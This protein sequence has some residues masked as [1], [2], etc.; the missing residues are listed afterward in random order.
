[1]AELPSGTITF[2]FTDIEGSTRLIQEL[3]E[4]YEALFAAHD[5]LVRR[6]IEQAGGTE[7]RTEGDS[8]FVVFTSASDAVHAAVDV[9]RSLSAHPWPD[10]H[11][12]HVRMGLHTGEGTVTGSDYVGLDVHRAARIADAGHGGQ[13]LLSDVTKSLAEPALTKGVTT[14][15]LGNHTLK[16]LAT[17]E[18]LYQL[19]I[20]DHPADFPALRSEVDTRHN[21]PVRPTSFVGRRREMEEVENLLQSSSLVTLTGIG[22]GGKTR[23]GLELAEELVDGYR[24]GVWFVD[25]APIADPAVVRREVA[26]ALGTVEPNLLPYLRGRELLLVLDA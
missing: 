9:Q 18:H 15:D 12:I 8:F 17:P 24:D 1:M 6:A 4:H 14:R 20:P 22:G 11:R 21:L 10:G 16:D 23:L 3:P 5:E 26:D 25:L 19:V 2:L 7:V 13:V